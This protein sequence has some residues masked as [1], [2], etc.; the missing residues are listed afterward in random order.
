[1]HSCVTVTMPSRTNMVVDASLSCLDTLLK[2]IRLQLCD[3]DFDNQSQRGESV[4]AADNSIRLQCCKS[5]KQPADYRRLTAYTFEHI[6]R[7]GVAEYR[8]V[9]LP[10]ASPHS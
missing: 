2:S 5:S 1:M 8:R 9:D 6:V 3:V 7:A 4:K 10:G